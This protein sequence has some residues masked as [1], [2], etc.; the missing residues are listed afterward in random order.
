MRD[1]RRATTILRKG[2]RHGIVFEGAALLVA[3][4]LRL[5]RLKCHHGYRHMTGRQKGG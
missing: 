1:S 3:S 4:T 5:V 2:R